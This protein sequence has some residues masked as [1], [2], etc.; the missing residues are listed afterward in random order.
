MRSPESSAKE[1]LHFSGTIVQ[2]DGELSVTFDELLKAGIT[3]QIRAI[4]LW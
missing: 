2:G 3:G 4:T 1:L